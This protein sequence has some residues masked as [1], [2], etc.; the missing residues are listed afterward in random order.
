MP[1]SVSGHEF[2]HDLGTDWR[3]A[4]CDFHAEKARVVAETLDHLY[5]LE[6]MFEDDGVAAEFTDIARDCRNLSAILR[7]VKREFELEAS[8]GA[9]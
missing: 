4:R 3:K 6:Q 8:R 7:S 9:P 1:E 5:D 2:S